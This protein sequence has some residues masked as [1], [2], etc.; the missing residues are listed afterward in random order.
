MVAQSKKYLLVCV[1]TTIT[2]KP[3]AKENRQELTVRQEAEC[4]Y[5]EGTQG[6]PDVKE[7]VQCLKPSR[8][9]DSRT[10]NLESIL[11]DG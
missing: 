9:F 5:R 7:A 4:K 11:P 2:R 10:M 1:S 3:G 6:K 8:C